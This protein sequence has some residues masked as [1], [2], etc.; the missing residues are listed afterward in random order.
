M[1]GKKLYDQFDS[2]MQHLNFPCLLLQL[3]WGM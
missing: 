3:V 2:M 1:L